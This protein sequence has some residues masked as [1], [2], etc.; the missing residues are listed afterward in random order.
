MRTISFI[1]FF[2]L[3]FQSSAQFLWQIHNGSVVKWN[4]YDGDEF[5]KGSINTNKWH[6]RLPWSGAVVSQDIYYLDSNITFEPGIVKFAIKRQDNYFPL[7]PWEMDTVRFKKNKIVLKDGNKFPFKWTGGLVYTK[8]EYKYGYFEIKFKAPVGQGI[9]PAFWL[10]GAKPNNEIDFFEL[11]GEKENSIHV[12]IHCPNG[13]GNYKEG[14]FGYRRGWGHWVDV[15]QK[16][17]S[18]F[19]VMAG[20]W[21]KD[22]IKWYLN[23]ELIAYSNHSFDVPMGMTAGTGIAKD[24]GPFKPGPNKA[25]PFPNYFEVD[26]IR[27]YKTDT[28]PNYKEI[29][30]NLYTSAE[31]K[32][33]D[34]VVDLSIAKKKGRLKNN[35]V[36]AVKH[37]KVIT[38][39]VNQVTPTDVSLRVLGVSM[40]DNITIQF[41]A[42]SKLIYSLNVKENVEAIVPIGENKNI[43]FTAEV[44]GQ[45]I[46]DNLIIQ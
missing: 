16:L 13:C 32:S 17:R 25:T 31:N 43:H 22:H 23:G 26:Y 21:T 10:Y 38:I 34:P 42:N 20:E 12:D 35:P 3:Y 36:K 41:A 46:E 9:W 19:N 1:C 40:K 29:K 7:Q 44:N 37:D 18:G 5:N 33:A 11:K 6:T 2:V 30:A 39:S 4:Y 28:L 14:W 15:D 45:K 8:R 27:V 24:G